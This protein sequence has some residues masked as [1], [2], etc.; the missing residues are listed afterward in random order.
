MAW[1]LHNPGVTATI[2]GAREPGQFHEPAA[3]ADWRLTPAEAEEVTA[4]ITTHP[5]KA[6]DD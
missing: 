5:V 2:I 3:A 1:V 6:W 4:F